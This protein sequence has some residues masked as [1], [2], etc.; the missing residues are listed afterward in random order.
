MDGLKKSI[1]NS[2]I[3][4]TIGLLTTIEG[5]GILVISIIQRDNGSLSRSLALIALG[6]GYMYI[7]MEKVVDFKLNML[8]QHLV[9]DKT[10]KLRRPIVGRIIILSGYVVYNSGAILVIVR[11]I[12]NLSMDYFDISL[13][14][15]AA[16][17][18]LASVGVLHVVNRK[19]DQMYSGVAEIHKDL[20]KLDK[21][22]KEVARLANRI[23]PKQPKTSSKNGKLTKRRPPHNG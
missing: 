1:I 17:L 23:K 5:I 13:G 19:L 3:N 22:A 11:Y 4:G 9:G 12:K 8:L 6:F 20:Q 15:E 2:S 14:L 18:T 10:K 21:R 16:G 7:S